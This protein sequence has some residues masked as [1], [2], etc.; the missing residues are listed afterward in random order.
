MQARWREDKKGKVGG[1]KYVLLPQV[2][3]LGEEEAGEDN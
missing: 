2:P 1:Q 3:E